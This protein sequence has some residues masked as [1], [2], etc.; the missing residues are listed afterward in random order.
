MIQEILTDIYT[1]EVPLIGNPLKA[2]NSYVIKAGDRSL[3]ID[4][5][6]NREECLEA[7]TAAFDEIHIDLEKTDFFITHM[8]ADH[9]G[10]VS[11]LAGETSTVYLGDLDAQIV[12]SFGQSYWE[13]IPHIAR[14]HGF[15]MDEI[16]KALGSHP[17]VKYSSKGDIDVRIVKDGDRVSIGDYNFECIETPGHTG[18]HICLY[19]P[20]KK[21][22]VSGDHILNNITPNISL[23]S[24]D[25]KDNPLRDFIASL[26][27][28]RGLDVDIVLP[29]HRSRFEN[30]R[31]R[32]DEL[33]N[34]HYKRADEVSSILEGGTL[35]TYQV[36][37]RMA[38]NLS[39]KSWD[40]FPAAQKW[41]AS[42]EAHAHLKYLED[43]GEI[44][45]ETRDKEVLFSLK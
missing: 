5:G 17:G 3:V 37:S 12:M 45:R 32:I 33:K 11:T 2:T 8:H 13:S 16:K 43:N 35:N 26:D 27:K 29:G 18:G 7:M 38:W 24:L 42:G 39:Y 10:L 15:P 44:Q 4:T 20:D 40:E 36:A 28:V 41:F 34:H 23:W 14:Q 6:M 21:I 22:F 1:F 19:E 9:S 30:F 25:E 31:G